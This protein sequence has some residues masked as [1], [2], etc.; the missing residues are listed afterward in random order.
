MLGES[1]KKLLGKIWWRHDPPGGVIFAVGIIGLSAILLQILCWWVGVITNKEAWYYCFR[2]VLESWQIWS[3]FVLTI[4]KC[5]FL[6]G[7]SG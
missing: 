7:G 3:G 1:P 6:P 2:G 5:I 4:V